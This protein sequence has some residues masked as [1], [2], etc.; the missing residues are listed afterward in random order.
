MTV[1]VRNRQRSRRV[2]LRLLRCLAERAADKP[3]NIALVNDRMIARLNR[4][5]HHTDGPTDVLSFD[6][7]DG[8]EVIVSV[9]RAAAQAR[10]YRTSPGRELALYVV[11]GILHLRGYDDRTARQ[12]ARMRAAER[13]VLGQLEKAIDFRR[14]L[15]VR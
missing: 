4:Q 10:R 6:Y 15:S 7:G 5:F 3:L 1:V 12:R 13:R 11:H 14:L 2:D 8:G 9:E